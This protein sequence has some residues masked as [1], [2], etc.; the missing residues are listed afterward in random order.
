LRIADFGLKKVV[1]GIPPLDPE[2]ATPNPTS[3]EDPHPNPLPEY[4]ERG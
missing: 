4:R 3:E 2:S 1:L